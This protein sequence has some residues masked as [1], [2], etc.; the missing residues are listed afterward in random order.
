MAQVLNFDQALSNAQA[1]PASPVDP[2]LVQ[3]ANSEWMNPPQPQAVGPGLPSFALNMKPP[4]A[5]PV[6]DPT[7][8]GLYNLLSGMSNNI[9]DP[10]AGEVPGVPVNDPT[11]AHQKN[12]QALT[13]APGPLDYL[14][15]F[16]A[17]DAKGKAALDAQGQTATTIN[18][19]PHMLAYLNANPGA[20][21]QAVGNPKVI[22][23]LQ[24]AF[25]AAVAASK[26]QHL[27]DSGDGRAFTKTMTPEQ[28]MH[29]AAQ[30][31]ITGEDPAAIHAVAHH[32]D[33]T[34]Q[35]FEDATK[36]LSWDQMTKLVGL[37]H[38]L[39]PQQQLVPAYL[40]QLHSQSQAADKALA[41][42][43]AANMAPAKL[44]ELQ[45]AAVKAKGDRDA[46]IQKLIEGQ[47]VIYPNSAISQ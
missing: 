24:D 1:A 37:Q 28:S 40:G 34:D 11:T 3:P 35:E 33:F 45:A 42:A 30:A 18:N 41:D 26:T 25:D 39:T 19:N 21:A 7:R 4:P 2:T 20:A 6:G 36:N 12:I 9:A 44:K 27:Y 16:V 29:V 46:V 23:G 10:A 22:G 5:A 31:K 38:Y 47:S 13:T 8:S 15:N 17:G 43:Q 32:G 14:G